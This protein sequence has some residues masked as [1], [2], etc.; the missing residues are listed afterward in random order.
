MWVKDFQWNWNFKNL[1]H[2]AHPCRCMPKRFTHSTPDSICKYG[3]KSVQ[4]NKPTQM[5]TVTATDIALYSKIQFNDKFDYLPSSLELTPIY[6]YNS[7]TNDGDNDCYNKYINETK[8]IKKMPN[9]RKQ[10]SLPDWFLYSD[11]CSYGGMCYLQAL[12]YTSHS[13]CVWW[14]LLLLQCIHKNTYMYCR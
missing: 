9:N 13:E 6:I 11:L 3:L 1:I 4:T 14:L 12:Y 8:T 10:Y 2:N 5:K 7:F